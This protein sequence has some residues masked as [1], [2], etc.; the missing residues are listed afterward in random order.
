VIPLSATSGGG[1]AGIEE[2][3]KKL[4]KIVV[5]LVGLLSL[6][7]V[8][9]IFLIPFDDI[10]AEKRAEITKDLELRL[11]RK[12]SFG[13]VDTKVFPSLHATLSDLKVAGDGPGKKPQVEAKSIEVK[14]ALL[15]ALV[16]LGKTIQIDKV[17]FDGLVVRAARNK[18][19]V[20]D[21]ESIGEEWAKTQDAPDPADDVPVSDDPLKG[22]NLSEFAIRNATVE[23]KDDL[24]IR[25]LALRDFDFVLKNVRAGAPLGMHLK[26]LFETEGDKAPFEV[27]LTFAELPKDLNFDPMPDA[28]LSIKIDGLALGPWGALLPREELA[29]H[30]GTLSLDVATAFSKGGAALKSKG[31]VKLDKVKV[32][33]NG[34]HGKALSASLN[35][36]VEMDKV[37]H[38]YLIRELAITGT[39]MDIKGSLEATGLSPAG[40]E[41]ADLK[42]SIADLGPLLAVVPTTS[43]LLPEGLTISGP[44][45]A[46]INGNLQ[47]V[48]LKVNLD[49]ATIKYNDQFN[50]KGGR[51]LH[52]ALKG[53]RDGSNLVAEDL[54]LAIDAARVSGKLTLPTEKGKPFSASLKS[55]DVKLASLKD[56]LPSVGNALAKGDT[57]AGGFSFA[58]DAKGTDAK[59]EVKLALG[60]KELDA[61]LARTTLKGSGGLTL[62][63]LPSG[64]ALAVK[65]DGNFDGLAIRSV[66]EEGNAVL[67]KNAGDSL[68]LQVDL[69]QK[70]E[71]LDVKTAKLK[72]G[73]TV[74]SVSGSAKNLGSKNAQVNLDFGNLQVAFDDLRRTLPGAGSLPAGGKLKGNLKISGNPSSASGLSLDAD[75]VDLSF[76]DSMIK[77]RIKVKNLDKPDLDINLGTLLVFFKDL[78][79]LSEGMQDL[80]ASGRLAGSL[81]LKGNMAKPASIEMKSKIDRLV[82]EGSDLGGTFELKNLD[83]PNF[84]FD[85]SGKMLDVDAL[86]AA[87]DSGGD[88]GGSKKK[89]ASKNKHGLSKG[90]RDALAKTNGKG[91]LKLKQALV[92]GIPMRDFDAQLVMK[93]GVVTFDKMDFRA[94]G[95][96]FTATGTELDLP[97]RYTGYKLKA[98]VKNMDLGDALATHTKMGS[99]F[100]GRVD[101]DI[102]VSGKGLAFADLASTLFGPVEIEADSL[103]FSKLDVLGPILGPLKRDRKMKAMNLKTNKVSTKKGTAFQDF[104]GWM[105]FEGGKWNL[106]KPVTSKTG[107]GAMQLSGGAGLDSKLN[108]DATALLSPA[109]LSKL[110]GGK[111]KPKANVPVPFKIAGTWDK[112]K[113]TGVDL[114]QALKVLLGGQVDAAFAA[115]GGEVGK[116]TS[117]AKGQAK[118]AANQAK[119]RADAERKKA[120]AEAKKRA[121]EAKKKTKAE[122]DKAKKKAKAEA[123]KAK[124][125]AKKAADKK[126]KEAEEKAKKGLKGIFGG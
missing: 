5:G 76:G 84:T 112:P 31:Q 2:T 54:V 82:A 106:R 55:G 124:K 93:N 57:V 86:T 47:G 4:L 42:A 125:K 72:A 37:D 59:Q 101:K 90:A 61:N 121:D 100:S 11:G 48:D 66:D 8:G 87:L 64:G 23:I 96:T 25:L 79:G 46:H 89:S 71:A 110:T 51:D 1:D 69:N 92:E 33:Q 40:L 32:T 70:A 26:G 30:A 45:S 21:Y 111:V 113:I 120:E 28:D 95:G 65:A 118:A 6:L 9:G 75:K 36:D 99:A 109:T 68:R 122:A 3:M 53:K 119:K 85:L 98:K 114:S 74:V 62:D 83:R 22:V 115:A 67:S 78:R 19:G 126:K 94:H 24:S 39:G 81:T 97:A 34:I 60:F 58:L 52:L 16:T 27:N 103:Q 41:N 80:P 102:D 7:F 104:S 35:V 12:V 63:V 105:E 56:L 14:V 13:K 15:K 10:M 44:V 49:Q 73:G 117:K 123:D 29:P 43:P 17:A 38:R 88:E 20:W 108:F 116:Q 50:K 18:E 107:F 91:S 77:G